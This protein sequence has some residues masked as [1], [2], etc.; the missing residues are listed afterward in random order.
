MHTNVG[1]VETFAEPAA[2]VVLKLSH[3]FGPVES[4]RDAHAPSL[5]TRV[6]PPL[7]P[8]A[9]HEHG[10]HVRPS[11][12]FAKKTACTVYGLPAGHATWPA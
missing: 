2:A 4:M 1:S 11:C 7:H 6:L 5:F 3:T 9:E 12:S 10:A 8:P